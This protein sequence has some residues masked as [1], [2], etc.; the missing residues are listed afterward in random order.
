[1][2]VPCVCERVG[3][4]FG[5]SGPEL[6][7]FTTKSLSER[8]MGEV[9]MVRLAAIERRAGAAACLTRERP[10]MII[11]MKRGGRE[12]GGKERRVGD[13][14]VDD[15]SDRS[16]RLNWGRSA[17]KIPKSISPWNLLSR[18]LTSFR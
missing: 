16:P 7:L 14:K 15:A 13:G 3:F 11:Y 1:M 18:V 12:G 17:G 9:V 2:F 5:E 10:N 8:A 6:D 4:L